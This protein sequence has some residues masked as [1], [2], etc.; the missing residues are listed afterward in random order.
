MLAH[1]LFST[2]FADTETSPRQIIRTAISIQAGAPNSFRIFLLFEKHPEKF[3]ISDFRRVLNVVC[4]LLG[5]SPAC[6]IQ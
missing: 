4:F 5:R 2:F 1:L 6:G 3:L